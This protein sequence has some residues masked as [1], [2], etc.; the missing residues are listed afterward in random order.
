MWPVKTNLVG[1]VFSLHVPTYSLKMGIRFFFFKFNFIN[2]ETLLESFSGTSTIMRCTPYSKT[3]TDFSHHTPSNILFPSR[4]CCH[5]FY[6]NF[7]I[8][9]RFLRSCR[10]YFKR[11][12]LSVFF[13]L[14]FVVIFLSL[15]LYV[16]HQILPEHRKC[17][18]PP[19]SVFK[20]FYLCR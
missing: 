4:K 13:F 12:F 14:K 6:I 11:A 9:M 16:Y 10:S 5:I 8:Y 19:D 20:L 1:G 2:C 7:L 18:V 17:A 3:T 15:I